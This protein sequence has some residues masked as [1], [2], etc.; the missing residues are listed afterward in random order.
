MTTYEITADE[1]RPNDHWDVTRGDMYMG[2]IMD[3]GDWG[4]KRGRFAAWSTKS[5]ARNGVVG[6]YDSREDA[7][8]AIADLYPVETPAAATDN[9]DAAVAAE[10]GLTPATIELFRLLAD[11]AGNWGGTPCLDEG[12]IDL[13]RAQRG[14]LT[15]L[16][17]ADL[18]S[19][20]R[21]EG[22]MWVDFTPKGVALA[23]R[24]G[25]ALR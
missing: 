24:L 3:E 1:H 4:Q 13:S 17:R 14:N 15:H 9:S 8:Q 7:A 6:F 10:L 16:K 18:L 21:S 11:D 12:N 23:D 19:T 22:A 2:Q 5:S 20:F 25:I